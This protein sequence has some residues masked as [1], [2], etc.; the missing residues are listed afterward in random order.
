MSNT[1]SKLEVSLEGYILKGNVGT[2]LKPAILFGRQPFVEAFLQRVQLDK[3]CRPSDLHG[4]ILER[5][6]AP[7]HIQADGKY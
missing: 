1:N 3:R 2:G 6:P 5:F 7:P 4:Q